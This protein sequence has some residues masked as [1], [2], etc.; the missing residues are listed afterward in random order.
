MDVRIDVFYEGEP[1]FPMS[2]PGISTSAA[3]YDINKAGDFVVFFDDKWKGRFVNIQE[4]PGD[5][6]TVQVGEDLHAPIPWRSVEAALT[7]GGR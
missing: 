2:M 5:R 6:V 1:L 7:A 4:I 3:D